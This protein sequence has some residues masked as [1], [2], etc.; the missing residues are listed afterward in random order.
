MNPFIKNSLFVVFFCF[1]LFSC[2][3]EIDFDS[4][5][6][7]PKI[8]IKSIIR[9]GYGIMVNVERS[10]SILDDKR[11]FEALPNAKVVLFKN[12]VFHT[13]LQYSS[14]VDTSR[15]HLYEDKYESIPYDN[16]YY[17][18]TSIVITAGA[19]YRLEV[20]SEGFEMATCETTVPF[21]VDLSG[22]ECEIE[23]FKH[24][25][26][27]SYFKV[28]AIV[29]IDDPA[30]EKNFYEINVHPF[31]GVELAILKLNKNGNTGYNYEGYLPSYSFSLDSIQ[32]TDTIVEQSHYTR[33]F[34]S[35]DP[36][37]TS[38]DIVDMFDS[39][40]KAKNYFTDEL[41][42]G[43]EYPLSLWVETNQN[44]NTELGEYYRVNVSLVNMSEELY[45]F[46]N[47]VEQQ[48]LSIDNPFAEPIPVYSNVE[49]GFGIFGSESFS[50]AY[51][52]AGDYPIEGKTYIDYNTYREI[53]EG[54][55]NSYGDY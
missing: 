41:L 35:T 39:E 16:G 3:K 24:E 28:K 27:D 1:T 33:Q 19:N 29:K 23:D 31:F 7:N 50:F 21:P 44:V 8:V 54:W 32:P 9:P 22:V 45:K 18:D 25:Y 10:K 51:T 55:I 47:S 15:I 13:E 17:I 43:K 38:T 34:Y 36:V 42:E 49:G 48:G 6:I 12:E 46:Y 30:N 2:E 20:S 14:R 5:L 4:E 52:I 40:S 37:L 26:Y 53:Y 11:Y